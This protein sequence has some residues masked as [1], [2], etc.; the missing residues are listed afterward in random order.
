M[1]AQ[2]TPIF[3]LSQSVL[4][5][6]S[7]CI[8]YIKCYIYK[9][10]VKTSSALCINLILIRHCQSFYVDSAR[11]VFLLLLGANT[12]VIIIDS[13]RENERNAFFLS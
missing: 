10:K 6:N 7:L 13:I 11:C 4:V 9:F 2:K 12:I 3:I 5:F 1:H 8:L